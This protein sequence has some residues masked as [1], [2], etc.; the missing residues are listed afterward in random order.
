MTGK[1]IASC[2]S[3]ESTSKM[4]VRV[5]IVLLVI[6]A[7]SGCSMEDPVQREDGQY[8]TVQVGNEQFVMFA[9]SPETIRLATENFQGKNNRHPAGRISLSNGGFNSPYSWHFM[10]DTIQMVEV[11]IELCDGKPSYVNSHL[12]DYLASG[13]CPWSG[14][15]IKVGR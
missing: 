1:E 2:V 10:P 5:F 12:N 11:S 3:E 6:F 8:F 14:K 4:I 9:T 7:V 13:Y 15:V